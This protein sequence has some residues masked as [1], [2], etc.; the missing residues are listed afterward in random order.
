MNPD[1]SL[2]CRISYRLLQEP[3]II[4]LTSRSAGI[5]GASEFRFFFWATIPSKKTATRVA[6]AIPIYG[7][8]KARVILDSDQNKKSLALGVWQLAQQK[9]AFIDASARAACS[10]RRA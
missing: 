3:K 8:H 6:R 9:T 1:L 4:S 2:M 5:F 7:T 10:S